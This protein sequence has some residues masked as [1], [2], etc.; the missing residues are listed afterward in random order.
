MPSWLDLMTVVIVNSNF[1]SVKGVKN[2]VAVVYVLHNW[3]FPKTQIVS[4]EKLMHTYYSYKESCIVFHF[5]VSH[6]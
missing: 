6:D 5:F 3:Y 2:T 4:L 1:E